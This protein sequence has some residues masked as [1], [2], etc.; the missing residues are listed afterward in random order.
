MKHLLSASDL[1]KDNA[2]ELLNLA[3]VLDQPN[4]ER[5]DALK[6][7]LVA[8]LFFED[9]TRTRFSFELAAK[10]LSADVINFTS[11]GSSVS[12][13]ESL[14]DTIL[15]LEAMGVEA[16]VIRHHH[17]GAAQTIAD[18][19]WSKSII[20]NAGDGTHQHPT[21]ALSDAQTIRQSL[22]GLDN[23][24]D[25]QG[26]RVLIVGDILHSRVARSNIALLKTLGANVS[27]CGPSTLVPSSAQPLVEEIHYD[28]DRALNHE[29]DVVMMLRIQSE[30]MHSGFVPNEIEYSSLWGLT[31][32]RFARLSRHT[33]VMHPGPMNRGLEI[34]SAAADSDQSVI[35]KQVQNGVAV[36]MAVLHKLLARE[37]SS[38]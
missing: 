11:K 37:T 6:G 5:N 22:K 31:E 20:I 24:G 4:S 33:L 32:K 18:S 3:T 23:A 26:L 9:S 14:K 36:R 27:L 28:F 12:K 34:A 7:V 2:I 15:T 35:V 25:L 38:K 13:G 19:S 21:Q 8:N 16:F 29:F 1:S 30:R 10:R 17:S